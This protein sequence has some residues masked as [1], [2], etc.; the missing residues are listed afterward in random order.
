ML[1]IGPIFLEQDTFELHK[2]IRDTLGALEAALA[3]EL[4]NRGYNVIGIHG[5]RV[6]PDASLWAE[7]LR[8]INPRFQPKNVA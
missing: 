7:V 4:V 3:D 1:A 6:T 5:R 8:H 2:P